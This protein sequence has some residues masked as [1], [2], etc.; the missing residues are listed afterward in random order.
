ML[1]RFSV[2]RLSTKIKVAPGITAYRFVKSKGTTSEPRA[3]VIHLQ[4]WWGYN[5]VVAEQ[6]QRVANTGSYEVLVPDLYKGKSALEVAEAEHLMNSLD[7]PRALEEIGSAVEY[8]RRD[9]PHRKVGVIGTCMGSALALAASG[10]FSSAERRLNCVV[11][12]YGVPPDSLCA[13]DAMARNGTPT[14][15]HFGELDAMEGFSDPETARRLET[16]FSEAG[17]PLESHRYAGQGHA[18]VNAKT[19][20][21]VAK[22]KEMGLPEHSPDAIELA[23]SRVFNFFK[24]HL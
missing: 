2:R 13:L 8:L 4:E 22:R 16:A 19:E 3:A 7:W 14:Q 21:T 23:W 1:F 24:E 5:D 18:F 17:V 10:R 11:G 6:A 15:V 20:W 12:F 9:E